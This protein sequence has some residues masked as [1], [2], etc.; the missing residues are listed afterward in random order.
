MMRVEKVAKFIGQAIG[1]K[2]Y[3]SLDAI[4]FARLDRLSEERSQRWGEL[5]RDVEAA[6]EEDPASVR[7]QALAVR[8][9]ALVREKE[10]PVTRVDNFRDAS[11]Q[12]WPQDASMVV[13]NQISRLYRIEQVSKF[14]E[15]ALAHGSSRQNSALG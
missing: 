14:L 6:L 9:T 10:T 5:F 13:V 15:K 8:W 11:R 12:K 3:G 7:A 1:R 4:R 2:Y